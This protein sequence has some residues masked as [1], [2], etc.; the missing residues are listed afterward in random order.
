M[1]SGALGDGGGE[2]MTEENRWLR[3]RAEEPG[4]VAW[5]VERFRRLAAEGADL[6]G[7]ARLVDA[8]VPR[9][10][11]ILDAGCGTGRVGGALAALGHTVI[12]VDLDPD[13]IAVASQDHPGPAWL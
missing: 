12:G 8:M 11:R 9:G 10:A 3:R 6:A 4:H 13:L 1:S 5:Y 2:H 7:E